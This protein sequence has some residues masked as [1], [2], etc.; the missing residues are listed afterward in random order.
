M[1]KKLI[2]TIALI[3]ALGAAG[4][5]TA[6]AVPPTTRAQNAQGVGAQGVCNMLHV[7]NS[8]V[9]FAG[10]NNSDHGSGYDIMVYDLV[11]PACF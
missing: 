9:G 10:M 7:A 3:F 8:A 2:T 1:S 11:I 4:A 6:S 5:S